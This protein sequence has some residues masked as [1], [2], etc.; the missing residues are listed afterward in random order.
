M[1]VILFSFCLFIL[2]PKIGFTGYESLY[3]QWKG[4]KMFQD[5]NSYDGKTYFL[6]NEGEMILDKESIRLYYYP[7][8]KSAEF[9]VSYTNSTII[10]K[11]DDK[12]IVCNY[13]FNGDTLAFEMA[14]INKVFVKLFTRVQLEPVILADLD[15]YGYRLDKLA[16]EFELDTFHKEAYK[17]FKSIDSLG[18]KPPK[19]IKFEDEDFFVI[20]RKGKYAYSRSFKRLNY[21]LNGKATVF[22]IAHIGGTQ[23]IH[24]K[25]ITACECDSI[26]IPYMTVEWANRIRKA[27]QDEEDF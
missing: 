1:R 9:E 24:L 2:L 6:P 14:Y 18:F 11:I 13:Q 12:E 16:F 21:T 19:F 27:I 26:T 22:E 4:I 8:F 7:Y 5:G 17:G 3:G 20:N 10:Y 23:A 15:K 25:P